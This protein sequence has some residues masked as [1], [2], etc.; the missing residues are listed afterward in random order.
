MVDTE[1]PVEVA[2]QHSQ[3]GKD[4]K[5][6]Q[7]VCELGRYDIVVGALQ[8]AR[9]FGSEVYDV[10]DSVVLTAGR[11][12]PAQGQPVQRGEGVALVLRGLGLSAWRRGGKLWKAWSPRCVS[13]SLQMDESAQ[14]R[15]H[16]IS[17][18]APTRAASREDK[19]AFF[20][21]HLLSTITGEVCASWRLQC[22]CRV[23][24]EW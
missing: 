14:S 15:L 23:Q 17:C 24:G 9:W 6:D 16:V 11:S 19:E 5:V 1:G 13:A 10:G 22:S 3:C 4:R 20:Q 7:V 12:T 21:E 18:Y 2:S 8:E